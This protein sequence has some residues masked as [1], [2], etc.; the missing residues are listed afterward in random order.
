[1]NI[2]RLA[3]GVYQNVYPVLTNYI[4]QWL[5][6]HTVYPVRTLHSREM[7]KQ[8]IN[9]KRLLEIIEFEVLK[10]DSSFSFCV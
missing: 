1:M 9:T 4:Q 6:Y 3:L 8:R 10:E 7:T 5:Q 2:Y